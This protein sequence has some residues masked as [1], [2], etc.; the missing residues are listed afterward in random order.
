M[1]DLRIQRGNGAWFIDDEFWLQPGISNHGYYARNF[2]RYAMT[3]THDE[4]SKVA[5]SASA[6]HIFLWSHVQPLLTKCFAAVFLRG[7]S[8]VS[9][10][11]ATL[12]DSFGVAALAL[13][14]L[15]ESARYALQLI[16]PGS[17]WAS[18]AA[19]E[20]CE[21]RKSFLLRLTEGL[22]PDAAKR[23]RILSFRPLIEHYYK[24]AKVSPPT[25]RSVLTKSMAPILSGYFA[26]SWLSFLSYIEAS[27]SPDDQ[28][29]SA[30]PEPRI[31]IRTGDK[32]AEAAKKLNI[33]VSDVAGVVGAFWN[34]KSAESPVERRL[35]VMAE[36]WAE[37]D[38][39]HA[40]QRVGSASLWGLVSEDEYVIWRDEGDQFPYSQGLYKILLSGALNKEINELW[41]RELL[42]ESPDLIVDVPFPHTTF[43]KAFGPGLRF[44]NGCALTS[45]FLCEG[46]SSRTDMT[47]LEHYHRKELTALADLDCPIPPQ[48]FVDLIA[49]QS[50]LG[51][52]EDIYS[53]KSTEFGT[54][55]TSLG[56]RREGFERLRDIVSRHRRTWT[57]HYLSMYVRRKA[58]HDIRS[59]AI[60]HSQF[61]ANKGKQPSFRAFAKHGKAASDYWFGGDIGL[62][63]AAM[64]ERIP[65]QP[66]YVP[67]L[68]FDASDFVAEIYRK[69]GGH[70]LPEFGTREYEAE[71]TR[72]W[73]LRSLASDSLRL[74]QMTA[75]S[76]RP[77]SLDEFGRAAFEQRFQPLG[78]S[79]ESAWVRYVDACLKP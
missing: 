35:R 21:R 47:G 37:F 59:F 73:A 23:L 58:E 19:N 12:N 32:I 52:P 69:L 17:G 8:S 16:E 20:R 79:I 43:A 51:P 40:N 14:Q 70:K 5:A 2:P 33:P 60:K 62:L 18:L 76:K 11:L 15:S 42:L 66:R 9:T 57:E 26:G 3:L 48:L 7:L 49:A 10:D 63:Y 44:W 78:R 75:I 13:D 50:K 61:I 25:H 67:T 54:I 28:I 31:L 24:K 46:P 30:I 72:A 36:Y 77:P 27:P 41:H 1:F 38:R 65:E 55:R 64:G 29:D 68:P 53:E 4:R 56:S 45:W 22:R 39:L 74:V 71:R 6:H 34:E